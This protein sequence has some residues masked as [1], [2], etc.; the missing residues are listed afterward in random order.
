MSRVV[1]VGLVLLLLGGAGFL[2]SGYAMARR[3]RAYYDAVPPPEHLFVP[4]N[5]RSFEAFGRPVKLEDAKTAD[6]TH[7]LRVRFGERE[8]L[9]PVTAPVAPLPDLEGYNEWLEVLAFGPMEAGRVLL[10]PEAGGDATAVGGAG[11]AGGAGG[12][13]GA[14]LVIVKRN[15]APG[16]EDDPGGLVARSRW[17]FDYIE[18]KPDGDFATKR[19]QFRNRRGELPALKDDPTAAVLPIEERSWEWQAALYVIPKLHISNYRYKVDAISGSPE[20][21]GMGWTLPAAGVSV[22]VLTIGAGMV[23][24]GFVRP[25]ARQG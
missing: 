8:L 18:L 4:V 15:A 16:F 22:L 23:A 6:G 19:M 20:H 9:V 12:A 25:R 1:Q 3:V 7:A 17:T 11:A 2:A 5:G 13:G 14:R 24:S 10:N 21:E